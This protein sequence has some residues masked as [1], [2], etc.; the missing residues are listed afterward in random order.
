MNY[1]EISISA[2]FYKNSNDTTKPDAIFGGYKWNSVVQQQEGFDLKFYQ[3]TPN[4]LDFKVVTQ[5]GSGSRTVKTASNQFANST[6]SWHHV[7]GVYNKATGEQK[8]YINGQLVSTQTHPAG[9]TIVPLTSYADMRTGYSRVNNGYFKG[10]I[11]DVRVYKS[12]LSEQE[13]QSLYN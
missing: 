7:V 12:A 9:N 2:W 1:D 5:D 13:A 8:L 11:D 3:N 4:K 10:V 6:G